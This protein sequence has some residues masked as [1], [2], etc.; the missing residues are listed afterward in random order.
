MKKMF[1]RKLKGFLCWQKWHRCVCK[2]RKYLHHR[3]IIRTGLT[4]KEIPCRACSKIKKTVWICRFSPSSSSRL[5]RNIREFGAKIIFTD[6]GTANAI[7]LFV[8]IIGNFSGLFIFWTSH[9]KGEFSRD[10][11]INVATC[12]FAYH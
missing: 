2:K 10:Y 9:G 11:L 12:L 4:Y 1:E 8:D 7:E 6:P 5:S 3:I